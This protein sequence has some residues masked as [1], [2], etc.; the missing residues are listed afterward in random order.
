I[1]K[2]GDY[3]IAL[4]GNQGHLHEDIKSWFKHAH[5]TQFTNIAHSVSYINAIFL[6]SEAVYKPKNEYLPFVEARL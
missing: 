5:H 6:P 2:G 4:K 1:E 3:V